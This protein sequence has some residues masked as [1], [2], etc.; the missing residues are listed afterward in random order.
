MIF[1][2]D[3][4]YTSEA[5][6]FVQDARKVLKSLRDSSEQKYGLELSEFVYLVHQTLSDVCD[7]VV[8]DALVE[9]QN[10]KCQ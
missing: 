2:F 6:N 8:L 7:E 9:Y 1:G 3:R 10:K 5:S 4:R